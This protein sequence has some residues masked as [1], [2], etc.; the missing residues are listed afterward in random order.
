MVVVG[1]ALASEVEV[2]RWVAEVAE[3]AA[4]GEA[5]AVVA[6]VEVAAVVAAAVEE[7]VVWVARAKEVDRVGDPV[8]A[9]VAL[10]VVAPAEAAAG[11]ALAVVVL[12]EQWTGPAAAATV[13]VEPCAAL[14]PSLPCSA[15]H[16]RCPLARDVG[17]GGKFALFGRSHATAGGSQWTDFAA[18]EGRFPNFRSDSRLL[19]W[20]TREEEATRQRT[21]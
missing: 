3:R 17:R 9:V 7:G 4:A 16:E 19:L 10:E 18:F 6:T 20:R 15:Q 14:A 5:S 8:E 1:W 11:M 2:G 13:V 12:A 21:T